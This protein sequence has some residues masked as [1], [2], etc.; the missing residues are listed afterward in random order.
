MR[1]LT[2]I[3]QYLLQPSILSPSDVAGPIL[4][5]ISH[6]LRL[7]QRAHVPGFPSGFC[8]SSRGSHSFPSNGTMTFSNLVLSASFANQVLQVLFEESR[9]ITHV[10]SKQSNRR[11][12]MD[13]LV[14]DFNRL[15]F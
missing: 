12:I 10:I 1:V 7:F 4:K 11:T 6:S 15:I 3:S 2:I 14:R 9:S 8:A 5:S 13:A